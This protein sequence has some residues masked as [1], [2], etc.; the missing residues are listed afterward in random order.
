M[1]LLLDTHYALWLT[2]GPGKL[3]PAERALLTD[4]D[5]TL[6]VSAVSLWELRIKWEQRD[7]A[8]NRKGAASPVD[9][10]D[11]LNFLNIACLA[12]TPEQAAIGLEVP[13]NHK[14]PFDLQL[15]LHAQHLGA[16][17][18]TRDTALRDHPLV[19]RWT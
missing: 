2:R 15:L 1:R 12:L 4:G 9:V 14:D 18:L 5:A 7:R 16:K 8:G 6:V 19:Y 17:L 11:T 10:L 13:I 3:S